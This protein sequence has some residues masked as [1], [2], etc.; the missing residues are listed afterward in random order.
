VF[1]DSAPGFAHLD[2]HF[3]RHEAVNHGLDEYVR[4]EVHT[5]TIENF[6]SVLKRMLSGTYISVDAKHLAKY[7]EEEIF[8]YNERENEDGPRFVKAVKGAEGK[9]LT[10][11]TLIGKAGA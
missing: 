5:N 6:W 10:Y 7:V 3:I 1:T 9:R 8:R 11:K 4:G 2:E